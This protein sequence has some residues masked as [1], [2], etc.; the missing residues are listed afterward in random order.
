MHGYWL[1]CTFSR[2]IV[3]GKEVEV[4]ARGEEGSENFNNFVGNE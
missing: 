2:F 4:A 3:F 1:H